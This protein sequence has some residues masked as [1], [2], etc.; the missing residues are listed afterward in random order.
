MGRNGMGCEAV[1]QGLGGGRVEG[2]DANVDGWDEMGMGFTVGGM[3]DGGGMN[4]PGMKT[5]L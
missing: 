2:E 4:D 1:Y 3:G 5:A